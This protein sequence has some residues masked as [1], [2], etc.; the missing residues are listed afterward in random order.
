ML[1]RRV[2]RLSRDSQDRVADASALAGE[3]INAVQTV[4][5]FTLE[6]LQTQRFREAVEH[7]FAVAVRRN[8]MRGWLTA[9]ATTFV[10]GAITLVLWIGARQVL[11]GEHD[12]RSAQPV[13]AVRGVHGRSRPRR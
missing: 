3:T 7:S 11:A 5:A 10:F 2:R 4:Q 6:A 8:R 13:P 1:G 12:V 9:L